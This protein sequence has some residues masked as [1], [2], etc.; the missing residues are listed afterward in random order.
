MEIFS[1]GPLELFFI[2]LIALIVLGPRDMVKAGRTIGRFLNR[3]VRSSTWKAIQRTTQE[4]RR[5]PSY[6]MREANLEEALKE[7]PTS[8]TIKKQS[9][10]SELNATLS[11]AGHDLS[12]WLRPPTT[13]PV[14]VEEKGR[15]EEGEKQKE[16]ENQ[17]HLPQTPT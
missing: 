3:A 8:E 2:L 13:A 1:I 15:Q 4:L 14:A 5:L 7:L 16:T 6:L 12:D 11:Q 9:G 17:T 10:F